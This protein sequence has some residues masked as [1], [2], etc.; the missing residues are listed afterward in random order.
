MAGGIYLILLALLPAGVP[1]LP[2][3]GA[4]MLGRLPAARRP[5]WHPDRTSLALLAVL[6]ALL[7]LGSTA[8]GAA[9]LLMCVGT[10]VLFQH[11]AQRANLAGSAWSLPFL[12]AVAALVFTPFTVLLPTVPDWLDLLLVPGDHGGVRFRFVFPE[13]NPLAF[14]LYFTLLR[15]WPQIAAQGLPVRA[16]CIA[17]AFAGLVSIG[18]PL[19]IMGNGLLCL[20][21]AA[22]LPLLHRVLSI[23]GA[24]A[25]LALVILNPPANLAG[26]AD[27]LLSGED[28]SLNL[29]TWGALAIAE[30]TLADSGLLVTG[31]GIGNGR[32]QLE[33]NPYMA[34]FAAQD[35]SALPSMVASV[36]LEAGYVG[37]A[38]L[39]GLL[40]LGCWRGRTH[41]HTICSGLLL[42]MHAASGS[43]FFDTTVWAALGIQLATLPSTTPLPVRTS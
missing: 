31:A 17:G 33:D 23:A 28:N 4:L 1:L 29:R 14:V 3:L 18:S 12:C 22:R 20:S 41:M 5:T 7:T 19:A 34:L 25:L 40:L 43:Y 6:V 32:A 27:L 13:P 39:A 10:A 37:L 42:L 15:F 24:A 36:L 30:V 26:R 8:K 9:Q 2:A 21:M 11:L 35:E 38:A 16:L